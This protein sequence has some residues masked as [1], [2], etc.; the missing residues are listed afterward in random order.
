[1]TTSPKRV[2]LVTGG[3]RG[4]GLGIAEHLADA[5]YN[6]VINGRRPQSDVQAT[7]DALQE[8]GAEVLY[9][10]MDV[11]N[12]DE[13]AGMLD[14]IRETFGRLDVLV[15]NAGV[16]PSVRAD[17]LEAEASPESFD[18]LININLRGPYFL[19]QAAARWMVEQKQ[20]NAEFKGVIVNVSSISATVVSVNRGDYCISKAGVAMATQL[21]AA[22]LGE[23][24]LG[25]F[26]VRPGVIRTDMTAGVTEKYDKLFEQGLA[27]EPRWGEPSDIGKAVTHLA[28]GDLTYATG[29]VFMVD[30]GLTI[31]RL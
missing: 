11:S 30:G 31:Q 6:L 12:V 21:W 3:S 17:I 14:A 8:R 29:N 7:L 9:R 20:A 16:A 4:I 15:N 13:H 1:M 19:T 26:E 5:G 24:G 10:P 18:R 27:V 22:R 25:V 28:S 2:A 23:Y